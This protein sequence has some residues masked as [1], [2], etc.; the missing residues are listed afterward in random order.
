MTKKFI[1]DVLVYFIGVVIMAKPEL[2][3]GL[4]EKGRKKLY[5]LVDS[6]ADDVL[7]EILS[8]IEEDYVIV[9]D[10]KNLRGVFDDFVWYYEQV[11]DWPFEGS[12]EDFLAAVKAGFIVLEW[13]WFSEV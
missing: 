2:V 4:S 6:G 5:E 12:F 8:F 1:K 13:V 11:L 3:L 10:C 7:V 9:S